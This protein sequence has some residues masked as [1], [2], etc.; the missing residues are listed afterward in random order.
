MRDMNFPYYIRALTDSQLF[1]ACMVV[2]KF[3]SSF[4]GQKR[5]Y[6]HL[7]LPI[8]EVFAISL[9]EHFF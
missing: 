5:C 1:D 2:L 7:D 4:R 6:S 9:I 3:S 8:E